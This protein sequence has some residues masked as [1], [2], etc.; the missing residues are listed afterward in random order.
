MGEEEGGA[1][2]GREARQ[3]PR[4]SW[5][6]QLILQYCCQLTQGFEILISTLT[7]IPQQVM[8]G[9]SPALMTKV[10]GRAGL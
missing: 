9:D 2:E 7:P 6:G 5:V 3:G 10:P 4:G 8:C 1:Q